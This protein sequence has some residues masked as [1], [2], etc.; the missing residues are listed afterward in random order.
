MTY[1]SGFALESNTIPEFIKQAETKKK[2]LLGIPFPIFCMLSKRHR[3]TRENKCQYHGVKNE[4]E[5]NEKIN[6]YLQYIYPTQY[7]ECY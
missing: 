1:G 6:A 2:E 7:G 4:E 5:S 3:T